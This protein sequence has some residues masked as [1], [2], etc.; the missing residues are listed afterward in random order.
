LSD[1]APALV[2]GL[3]GALNLADAGQAATKSG[4]EGEY[5]Q[6]FLVATSIPRDHTGPGSASFLRRPFQNLEW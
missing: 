6:E 3:F 1:S 4:T 5:R 2:F